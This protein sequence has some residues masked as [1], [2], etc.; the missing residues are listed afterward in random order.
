MVVNWNAI[1]SEMWKANYSFFI[2]IFGMIAVVVGILQLVFMILNY[3][4]G[5][6]R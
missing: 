3:L 4:N 2:L 1:L 6:K 5:R